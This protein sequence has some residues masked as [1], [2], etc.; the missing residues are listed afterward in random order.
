MPSNN[1]NTTTSSPGENVDLRKLKSRYDALLPKYGFLWRSMANKQ[2]KQSQVDNAKPN[3]A[4]QRITAKEKVSIEKE[5]SNPSSSFLDA[6]QS[7]QP[8]ILNNHNNCGDDCNDCPEPIIEIDENDSTFDE[9]ELVDSEDDEDV[10]VG[11]KGGRE[12]AAR[13][14]IDLLD[15]EL[16][17][18]SDEEILLTGRNNKRTFVIES[19]DESERDLV[20]FGGESEDSEFADTVENEDHSETNLTLHNTNVNNE[21]NQSG[22]ASTVCEKEWV[23]LPSSNDEE[24]AKLPPT[25]TVVILSSDEEDESESGNENDAQSV[26]SIGSSD[27]DEI[28]YVDMVDRRVVDKQPTN[29]KTGNDSNKDTKSKRKKPLRSDKNASRTNETPTAS[30]SNL[31]SKSS[32]LAFRKQRDSILASTFATFNQLAFN[33]ELS[34]VEVSWSNRLNTTAGITRMKGRLGQPNS[35]VATIELATKVIDSEEKLRSTLLHELCH[36]AAWLVDGAHKPPHGKCFKKWAAISM[37]KVRGDI[38]PLFWVASIQ[39]C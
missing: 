22:D 15:V 5:N 32:S 35:R 36:A 12:A 33:G 11:N 14:E 7:K 2:L 37:K 34:S 31:S 24:E 25:N 39:D 3:E 19:D 30:T 20:S 38:L 17:E 28:I 9:Q 6:I 10:R 18:D 29:V 27:S 4:K 26:F 16:G 23:E 21:Q 13:V 1:V 8:V